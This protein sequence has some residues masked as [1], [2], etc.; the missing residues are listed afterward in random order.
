MSRSTVSLVRSTGHYGGVKAALD[1]IAPEIVQSLKG[2]GKILIKPNFVSTS[3]QLAATHVD[4][5][6]AVLDFITNHYS[7]KVIVAEGP[8][9]SSLQRGLRNFD[10][11]KLE[12][13]YGVDFVDLNED[14][15]MDVEVWGSGLNKINVEVA[16]TVIESDYRISVTPP[17]THDFTIVTLSI[18][19]MAVGSLVGWRNKS[20]IH[21]GY[22]AI[23]LNIAKIAKLVLPHLS[24]IDGFVGMDGNGPVNGEPVNLRIAIAGLD[25]LA[26][27]ATAARVMGFNPLEVGYLYY[28]NDWGV[29]EAEAEKIEVLGVPTAEVSRRFKPHRAYR[30]QLEWKLSKEELKRLVPP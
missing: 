5:V 29:G 4:A 27:D 25:A 24:V 3:K 9:A 6:R 15:S 21:Q 17:K 10:Y 28:L 18:K 22:K 16:K 13:E 26:V 19:N 30:E 20:R 1:L 14:N 12:G 23:N 7:G 8:S 11:L 2:K